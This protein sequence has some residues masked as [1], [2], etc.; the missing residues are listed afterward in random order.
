MGGREP[1]EALSEAGKRGLE[2]GGRNPLFHSAGNPRD[3][4]K[5]AGELHAGKKEA[6]GDELHAGKWQPLLDL[7]SKH[8][9]RI[10]FQKHPIAWHPWHRL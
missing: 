2:G 1:D 4:R 9:R 3:R 7:L 5:R 6:G 10:R 8:G